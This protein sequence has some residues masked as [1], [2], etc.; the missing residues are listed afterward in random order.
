[1]TNT[2]L[3]QF[4]YVD[5]R[6]QNKGAKKNN[7]KSIVLHQLISC[8]TV[9]YNKSSLCHVMCPSIRQRNSDEGTAV[10]RDRSP[11]PTRWGDGIGG[12]H[13]P[14]DENG[15][16][17]ERDGT[18]RERDRNGTGTGKNGSEKWRER[19]GNGTD[20]RGR[21]RDGRTGTGETEGNGRNDVACVTRHHLG[22]AHHVS[23]KR[24]SIQV[25]FKI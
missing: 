13:V 23:G 11:V 12:S 16:G 25:W 17:T 8:V 24:S 6:K 7:V 3:L 15:T 1:M 21:E 2:L 5:K 9:L 19:D 4:R 10:R 14:Y 20:G 18:G 22:N